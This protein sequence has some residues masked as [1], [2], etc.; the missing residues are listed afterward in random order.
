MQT[1]LL[2]LAAV[3]G[4]FALLDKPEAGTPMLT[5]DEIAIVEATNE[6]RKAAKLPAFKVSLALLTMARDHSATQARLM[7]MDHELEG[8]TFEDR[9]K[10]SKYPFRRAG[11]NVAMGQDTPKAVL[12]GWMNSPGHKAN[13]VNEEFE[14]IGVAVAIAKDG[15]KYWT[16]VFGAK[17][18]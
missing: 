14:E 6:E 7:K 17:R 18:K 9:L 8:V 2:G 13:I 3:V 5:K 16:Q 15:T 12:E 1:L 11:E 4:P 10:A